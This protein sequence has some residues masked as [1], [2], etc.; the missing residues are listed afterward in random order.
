VTRYIRILAVAGALVLLVVASA[1]AA[2]SDRAHDRMSPVAASHQASPGGQPDD[3]NEDGTLTAEHLDRL[4]VLLGEAGVSTDAATIEALAADHGVGGAVRL[5]VWAQE[6]GLSTDEIAGM[7]DED[8]GVGWGEI[9]QQ[10][11]EANGTSLHPGIGSVMSGGA[12]GGQGQ[13]AGLGREDAPGQ[14]DR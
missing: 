2:P 12:G 5:L 4:V 14:Q 3:A 6:S 13:G 1:L 10:L 11:N 7:L 9:A 8:A